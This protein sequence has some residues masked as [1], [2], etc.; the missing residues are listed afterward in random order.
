MGTVYMGVV[1]LVNEFGLGAAVIRDASLS[2]EQC[3]GIGGLSVGFGLFLF[4]VSVPLAWPIAAFFR[5]PA[6]TP[7]VIALSSTFAISGFRVLPNALLARER[8]FKALARIDWLEAFATMVTTL[9]LAILGFR[10]WSLV[11]GAIAGAVASTTLALVSRPHRITWPRSLQTV[12]EPLK[13]GWHVTAAR[14]AW[15]AYSNADFAVVGRMLGRVALGAYTFAWQISSIPVD[16]TNGI[17]SRVTLPVL[18]AVQSDAAALRRYVRGL[19]EGLSLV[20]FPVALG[21]ALV[22]D[23]FV[24]FALGE[25]WVPAIA[26]LRLLALY[27]AVRTMMMLFPPVLIAVGRTRLNMWLNILLSVTMPL[28]F[29]VGTRWGTTGVAMAWLI[30]YP[31]IAVPY[32]LL[33]TL[34]AIGMRPLEFLA[35]LRPAIVGSALMT[36]AVLAAKQVAPVTWPIGVRLLLLVGVGALAYVG[37]VWLTGRDRVMAVVSLVRGNK[38]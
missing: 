5:E 38:S 30:V 33:L 11:I 4:A 9:A 34:R 13:V 17:V 2:A 14:L 18:S 16:K 23:E 36:A 35:G 28:A 7:V 32:L 37:T 25:K 10:Y 12:L 20:G 19:S 8:S 29:I 1:Q 3:A 26:P 24:R 27:A 21:L 31:V 22:S 6:V 15:Y